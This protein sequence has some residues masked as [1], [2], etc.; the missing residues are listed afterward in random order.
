MG[1]RCGRGRGCPPPPPLPKHFLPFWGWHVPK[2]VHRQPRPPAQ[3]LARS[4]SAPFI[5]EEWHPQSHCPLP[6][7]PRTEATVSLPISRSGKATN[8]STRPPEHTRQGPDSPEFRFISKG[9]APKHVPRVS[10]KG[11][12]GGDAHPPPPPPPAGDPELL[13]APNKLFGLN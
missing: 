8:T 10:S 9:V 1:M 3:A 7:A 2:R 11:G 4:H 13:E 5:S 6:K 12:C